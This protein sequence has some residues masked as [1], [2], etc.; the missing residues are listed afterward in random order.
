MVIGCPI[1]SVQAWQIGL[2]GCSQKAPTA[3]GCPID[4]Q[5][6]SEFELLPQGRAYQGEETREAV[7]PLAEEGAEAQQQIH[8]Q[9]HPYLP[10]HGVGVLAKEVGQLK[11]LLQFL[12]ED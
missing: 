8:Q 1:E 2:L 5:Q 3:T 6:A 7:A 10:P 12:E 9:R 4:F 11:A